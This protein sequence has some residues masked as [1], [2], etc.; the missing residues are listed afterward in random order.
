MKATTCMSLAVSL[1]T[2]ISSACAPVDPGDV[3]E[4]DFTAESQQAQI[5]A[6]GMSLNGMSLN[7]QSLNG[8]SLNGMSLNGQSLNG[9]SL[10]GSNLGGTTSTNIPVSGSD[11]EG[12]EIQGTYSNGTP[13]TLTIESVKE[14]LTDPGLWL[15]TVAHGT[16]ESKRYPCDTDSEGRPI[17]SIALAGR[18]DYTSG[19]ATGGDHVADTAAVTFSCLGSTLAKCAVDLGY[20]PWLTVDETDGQTTASRSL[21]EFH[22]ACTRMLRADYCGDGVG[23]TFSHVPVNVWDNFGIQDPDVVPPSWLEDAEW[24]ADGAACI[25]NFRYDPN[26]DTTDYIDLNCPERVN[27]S[28]SC[29]GASSTFFTQHGYNTPMASRSLIRNEFDYDYVQQ[30]GP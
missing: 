29:F 16:G 25:A 5:I 28:F 19:T 8:Q 3:D 30:N 1:F 21:R 7:G 18:W 26:G 23:H 27:G 10:N 24:S 17:Q 22:Q 4:G 11:L 9:M 14:S 2:L 13:V 6:N 20:K 12:A 15:Y